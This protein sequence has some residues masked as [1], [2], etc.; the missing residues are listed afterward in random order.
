MVKRFKGW[1]RYNSV[2][3]ELEICHPKSGQESIITLRVSES[4]MPYVIKAIEDAGK[5]GAIKTIWLSADTSEPIKN[6][7]EQPDPV[8]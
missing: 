4:G 2:S 5:L 7:D 8:A 3:G 1:F 6:E